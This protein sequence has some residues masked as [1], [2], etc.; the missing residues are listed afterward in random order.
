MFVKAPTYSMAFLAGVLCFLTPCILPLVPGY[1]SYISGV[2]LA[3]LHGAEADAAG[4]QSRFRK[5][6]PVLI[7]SLAFIAGFSTIFTVSGL[8]VFK[9]SGAIAIHKPLLMRLA[10]LVIILLGL[11]MT[12][13]VPIKFLMQEKRLQE[14]KAGGPLR[15]YV[16]GM[17][18]AFGWSSCTG[19]ILGAI[20]GVAMNQEKASQA[21]I[22]M[23]CYSA[24]IG[25]PFLLT[26][27][28]VDYFYKFFDRIKKH[29]HTIEVATGLLII[30]IGELMLLDRFEYIHKIYPEFLYR[31]LVTKT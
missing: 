28:A 1:I 21:I 11:H 6:L 14:T 7:A 22:L 3:E 17:I 23:I 24:G 25:L 13:L 29:F 31:W 16:L 5:L 20:M 27:L 2:S 18:F 4:K 10:G 12:G 9:L 26:A 19:P 8:A 15:A 30:Q